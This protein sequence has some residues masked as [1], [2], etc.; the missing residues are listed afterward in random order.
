MMFG[1]V[2]ATALTLVAVPLL[3]FEFF[4]HRKCPLADEEET[5]E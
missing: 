4:R 1:A 2:A 5:E 3:Y